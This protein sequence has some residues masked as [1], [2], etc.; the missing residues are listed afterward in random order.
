[1]RRRLTAAAGTAC[2]HQSS[3]ACRDDAARAVGEKTLGRPIKTRQSDK[4]LK[5]SRERSP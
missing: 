2:Q 1:M 4:E 5:N 3:N